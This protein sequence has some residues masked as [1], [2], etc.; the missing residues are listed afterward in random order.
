[1]KQLNIFVIAFFAVSGTEMAHFSYLM[2]CITQ[3]QFSVINVSQEIRK[4]MQQMST[5]LS[6]ERLLDSADWMTEGIVGCVPR[7]C[8]CHLQQLA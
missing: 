8:S 5:C 1:M 2:G 6:A 4:D 7:G 3:L